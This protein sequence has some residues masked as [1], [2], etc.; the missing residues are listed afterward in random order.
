MNGYSD[1]TI[2]KSKHTTGRLPEEPS[3]TRNRSIAD[4][5]DRFKKYEDGK[6]GWIL[7]DTEDVVV[8]SGLFNLASSIRTT[9]RLIIDIRL[10][11][12]KGEVHIWHQAGQFKWRLRLDNEGIDENIYTQLY[13]FEKKDGDMIRNNGSAINEY[14]IHKSTPRNKHSEGYIVRNYFTY[15][16]SGLIRFYDARILS[17]FR[18]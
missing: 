12:Q 5:L 4:F 8:G 11:S 2:I 15:D 16:K 3:Y 14:I 7:R 18:S 13:Y 10:F 17:L 6:T 9:S 1:I